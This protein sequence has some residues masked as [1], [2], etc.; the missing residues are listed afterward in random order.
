MS[1]Q[2]SDTKSALEDIK[3]RYEDAVWIMSN[4]A[5]FLSDQTA[6]KVFVALDDIPKLLAERLEIQHSL[7]E[8]IGGVTELIQKRET[9]ITEIV[10]LRARLAEKETKI[11]RL[12]LAGE[13]LLG[14]KN[15]IQSELDAAD[16][17]IERLEME[18]AHY[19]NDLD[20]SETLRVITLEAEATAMAW[21]VYYTSQEQL[22]NGLWW[23][24][25][26]LEIERKASAFLLARN[27]IE[28]HESR[29]WYRKVEG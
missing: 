9:A 15:G 3:A 28:K 4:C 8:I 18:I 22:K 7:A 16:S 1:N 11:E 6:R 27:L 20:A 12:T 14:L 17:E 10:Q 19:K 24:I 26:A 13:A 25:T 23:H 5:T 21:Q 2:T 29:E